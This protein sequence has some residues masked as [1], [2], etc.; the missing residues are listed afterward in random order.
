MSHMVSF[1]N[2]PCC[3]LCTPDRGGAV[4]LGI[5][6]CV[7]HCWRFLR[8]FLHIFVARPAVLE[9]GATT[10][11]KSAISHGSTFVQAP[12]PFRREVHMCFFFSKAFL[13]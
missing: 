3:V 9:L 13:S 6:V 4:G 5:I 1:S 7:R 8:I 12:L 2:L 10:T 11:V